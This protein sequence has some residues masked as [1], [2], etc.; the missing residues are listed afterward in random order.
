MLGYAIWWFEGRQRRRRRLLVPSLGVL[1][2]LKSVNSR[3]MKSNAR[4]NDQPVRAQIA[5]E[6]QIGRMPTGLPAGGPIAA[7][8]SRG[9]GGNSVL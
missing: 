6:R 4:C 7:G 5:P 9:R 8:R 2:V 3:Q 1:S